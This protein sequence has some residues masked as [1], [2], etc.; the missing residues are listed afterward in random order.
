[1]ANIAGGL[2]SSA[3]KAVKNAVNPT[4]VLSDVRSTLKNSNLKIPNI[5][6]DIKNASASA[7][8]N[9]THT[10]EYKTNPS[11]RYVTVQMDIKNDALTSIVNGQNADRDAT[12]TF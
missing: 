11:Q 8:A 9:I 5:Q 2:G 10:L 7:N 12:F 1:M 3:V 4:D 6:G